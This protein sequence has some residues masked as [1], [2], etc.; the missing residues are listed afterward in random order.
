LSVLPFSILWLLKK[1]LCIS[2]WL[3][4]DCIYFLSPL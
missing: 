4:T 1:C 3:L 2:S